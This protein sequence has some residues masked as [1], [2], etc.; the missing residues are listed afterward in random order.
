MNRRQSGDSLTAWLRDRSDQE[1]VDLLA[2]RPDLATPLP[3]DLGVLAARLASRPSISRALD[4]LSTADLEVLQALCVLGPVN[5]EGLTGFLSGTD[6]GT[7]G[8]GDGGTGG[9]TDGGADGGTDG[10]TGGGTGGGADGGTDGGTEAAAVVPEALDRLL[11]EAIVYV[12]DGLLHVID[13][14]CDLCGQHPLGLGRPAAALL[15]ALD[16]DTLRLLAA[17]NR[18]EASPTRGG[19]VSAL[20]AMFTDAERLTEVLAGVPAAERAVLDRLALGPPCGSTPGAQR[21]VRREAARSPVEALLARGLLVGI[22]ATTVELPREV[23]LA[24]RGRAAAGALHLRPPAVPV[25]PPPG[26]DVDGAGALGATA[27]VGT[28]ERLL[29]SWAAEPPSL[30]RAGGLGTRELRAAARVADVAESAVALLVEVAAAAGLLDM[31]AGPDP[32]LLPTPTFDTWLAE[33]VPGRWEALAAAWISLPRLPGLIG[34]RDERGRA[35][36]ALSAEIE[37]PV[38][39]QLRRRVLDV[40]ADCPPGLVPAPDAVLDRVAWRFPRFGAGLRERLVTWTLEEAEVIAVTAAG[41]LTA[42]GRNLLA[43]LPAAPVLARRLPPPVSHVLV[44]ADLTAIAPGPLEPELAGQVGLIADVESAGAGTVYRFS[45]ASLRRAF[46]SGWAAGDVH[47]LLATVSQGPVPQT[48]TYLVDDVARRHGRLRAGAASAYLR[49]DDAALLAEVASARGMRALGVRLLAPTVLVSTAPVNHL[50]ERL[51][52]AGY[53]PMA[54]ASDGTLLV[55]RP[56]ERR[57]QRRPRAHR[58]ELTA[59]PRERLTELVT[60]LRRAEAARAATGLPGSGPR[61]DIAPSATLALLSRAVREGSRVWLGYVNREGTASERVVA[62]VKLDAGMLTAYDE[63]T[64]ETRTFAVH[65]MTA[66]TV[67]G[68]P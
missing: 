14:A 54:E 31:T 2:A 48:L 20:T 55:L 23:G 46:D 58:I 52:A 24:L 56:E 25:S 59:P 39:P 64:D 61:P 37:R 4:S 26:G 68:Q 41:G 45:G 12:A 63:L 42:A 9:G 13:A 19:V 38:A 44:Q 28:V 18:L 35:T 11:V 1:L 30:L 34:S 60:Q 62:P 33:Q 53:A 6:S 5:P 7:D 16:V 21:V 3:T 40:L 29:R 65:R 67:L 36:A 50:V 8:G 17:A 51:R 22:D 47:R 27:V 32:Q 57:T 15:A 49:C 43:G 66:V 10:G